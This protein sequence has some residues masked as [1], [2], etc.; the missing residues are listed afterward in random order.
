MFHTQL[1]IGL[2]S[3]GFGLPAAADRSAHFECR[4]FTA[5]QCSVLAEA[6]RGTVQRVTADGFV[7]MVGEELITVRTNDETEYHLDGQSAERTAVLRMGTNVSVEHENGVAQKV[8]ARSTPGA[9]SDTASGMIQRVTAESFVLLTGDDQLTVRTNSETEYLLDGESAERTAV[10]RAGAEVTVQHEDGLARKV[11]ARS[12][13]G[14]AQETADGTVQRVSA[15]G[16]VLIV[17]EEQISVR[18][19][20]Y[21]EYLLDGEPAERSTVLRAGA[22][23][24]VEHS[25]GLAAKVSA[26]ST[27]S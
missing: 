13:P 8:E 7:L 17:G 26:T 3:V 5:E 18:T 10:L 24:S 12:T 27:G 1:L 4:A 25:E 9:T 6:T 23:V 16:F 22:Q 11:E 14:A 15:E 21:T 20:A 19:N 2:V